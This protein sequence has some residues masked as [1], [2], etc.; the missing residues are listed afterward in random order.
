MPK[1]LTLAL[2][3]ELKAIGSTIELSKT[4]YDETP[5]T[6]AYLIQKGDRD[7]DF[8]YGTNTSSYSIVLK[9]DNMKPAQ[10]QFG[11]IFHDLNRSARLIDT[12]LNNND[13]E[14]II[15]HFPELERFKG[16]NDGK[17]LIAEDRWIYILNRF[18]REKYSYGQRNIGSKYR[19]LLLKAREMPYFSKLFPFTSHYM[20]RFA[21]DD[22]LKTGWQL[23]VHIVP[24]LDESNG[25]YLVSAGEDETKSK[26]FDDVEPALNYLAQV[27][28]ETKPT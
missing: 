18:F 24:T 23:G 1:N 14:S 2:Q 4:I 3:K 26:F 25:K 28:S 27:L 7:F 21:F 19:S 20:L 22:Q 16:F 11:G 12:W 6:Y 15:E 8:R 10:F 17:Q 13:Y 5:E 9:D